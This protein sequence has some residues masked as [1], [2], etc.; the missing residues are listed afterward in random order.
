M[1]VK[2]FLHRLHAVDDIDYPQPVS[3]LHGLSY[4]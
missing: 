4:R 2:Y 1:D 3:Q